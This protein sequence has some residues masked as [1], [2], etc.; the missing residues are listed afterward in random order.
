MGLVGG[1]SRLFKPAK[2]YPNLY[3]D[4]A[5]LGSLKYLEQAVRELPPEKLLFGSAVPNWTLGSKWRQCG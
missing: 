5:A 1:T 4:T 2:S 3:L